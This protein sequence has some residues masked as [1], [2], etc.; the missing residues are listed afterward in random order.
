MKFRVMLRMGVA[1]SAAIALLAGCGGGGTEGSAQKAASVLMVDGWVQPASVDQGVS[2]VKSRSALVAAPTPSKVSL[3]ALEESKT[4]SLGGGIGPRQVGMARDV[5]ATRTVEQTLQ[6]LQWKP[7]PSGGQVAAISF[8]AEGAHGL[9]L[10]VVAR[11]LPPGA[12]LRVYSQADTTTVFQIS[13]Q[14]VLQRIQ[15]NA[16]AG[17]TTLDGQTWWTPD[18]GSNEATLELELP[19]GANPGTVDLSVPRVSHIFENLSIPTEEELSTKIN[20]SA[21]CHLDASCYEAYANQR[22]AVARMIFTS[23]ANSF[24]CTGTL[25]NDSQSSGTPY[26]LTANHCISKQAEASSLQTDWFYR[27]PV[28]NSRTLSSTTTKRV[29]GA[30]LLYASAGTDTSFLRLNDTPPSG[31]V[32]AGWDAGTQALS[33]SVVGLHHPRGDLLKVSLGSLTSLTS[34]TATSGTE[35]Q[36]SGSSGNFYRVSWSEGTTEGGSSGSALFKDG[37]YVIGTLYGGSSS[38]SAIASPD[39]Y[40]RFDVAY[41][42]ALKN[43]LSSATPPSGPTGRV[44]V[45]RFYNMAGLEHFYTSNV[46]ERD[47]LINQFAS[48]FVYEGAIFYAYPIE[49]SNLFPVYRLVDLARKMHLYT[50]SPVERDA[51]RQ[52]FPSVALEG[53]AWWGQAA[54]GNGAMPVYRYLNRNTGTY[55]YTTSAAE[56]NYINANLGQQYL[57]QGI[58]FYVWADK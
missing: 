32:F 22:N 30:S 33:S 36:C 58:G 21:S 25:L 57:E 46:G 28:C 39:F 26:F 2:N 27:A 10:G 23:G 40:G 52:T 48:N 54:P 45:Y 14:E 53:T 8:S 15:R 4:A 37:A 31:A 41:N 34:C 19:A 29:N 17:D 13:G 49:G 56:R 1:W 42:A 16:Q 35:F 7:T 3:G 55:F 44:P 20:E 47:L 51:M 9:R 50:A 24:L 38:C 12:V 11:A 18:V 6:Q 43:W 5:A